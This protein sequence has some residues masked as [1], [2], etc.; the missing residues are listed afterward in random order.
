ME[1]SVERSVHLRLGDSWVDIKC[2]PSGTANWL[3]C[4][5]EESFRAV[6]VLVACVAMEFFAP[7]FV[8]LFNVPGYVDFWKWDV[9]ST[10]YDVVG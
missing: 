2:W 4:V 10:G 5:V 9:A 1:V 8:G 3:R 7:V 6:G